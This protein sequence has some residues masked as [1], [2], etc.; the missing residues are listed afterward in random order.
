MKS[1]FA[2]SM[3]VALVLVLSVTG[4]VM[5]AGP[6]PNYG[7]GAQAGYAGQ[8]AAL[9]GT[10]VDADGDQVCDNFALRTP[11]QDGNGNRWNAGQGPGMGNG[12]PGANFVDENGDGIC[13][14]CLSDGTHLQDGLGLQARSGGR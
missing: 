13:D 7:D 11:A 10:F 1:K 2:V 8:G 6:D 12:T 5:A 14:V 9:Y 4:M 3:L